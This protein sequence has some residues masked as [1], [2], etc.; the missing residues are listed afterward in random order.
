MKVA[1]P[2]ILSIFLLLFFLIAAGVGLAGTMS[3]APK[4]YQPIVSPNGKLQILPQI[5]TSKSDARKYLTVDFE[6]QRVND[7]RA[8]AQQQTGAS[9]RMKWSLRWL[10]NATIKLQSSD[11]G[12]KC[13]QQQEDLSWS[14]S[15]CPAE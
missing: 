6:V 12:N 7:G 3:Y 4:I 14:S 11:I 5:N 13:W 10:D 8:V 2:K 9:S 15:S 1:K